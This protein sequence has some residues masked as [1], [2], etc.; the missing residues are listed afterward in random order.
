MSYNGEIVYWLWGHAGAVLCASCCVFRSGI[1][2][3]ALRACSLGSAGARAL[4]FLP[5]VSTPNYCFYNLTIYRLLN[6]VLLAFALVVLLYWGRRH[7]WPLPVAALILC[8]PRV[9][10]VYSYANSD[11]WGISM[12]L[13]LFTFAV[14]IRRPL[15]APGSTLLLRNT[16]GPGHPIEAA[17]LDIP[18]R[19]RIFWIAFS[20]WRRR[21]QRLGSAS[22]ARSLGLQFLLLVATILV[23]IGPLKIVYPLSIPDYQRQLALMQEARSWPRW[24]PSNITYPGF[25]LAARGFPFDTVWRNPEWYASSLASLYGKFGYMTVQLPAFHYRAMGL[26]FGVFVALTYGFGIKRRRTLSAAVKL[27]LWMAPVFVGANVLASLYNSWTYDFQ[28]QGRYLFPALM[29]L[30]LMLAGVFPYEP[31]W[32]RTLR[33]GSWVAACLLCLATLYYYVAADPS[34]ARDD[35]L[36]L[37][38]EVIEEVIKSPHRRL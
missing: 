21:R 10:Y 13:F 18:C 12:S 34:L 24:K 35:E 3:V 11:A 22:A 14:V 17:L 29:P 38:A 26:L 27:A 31:R 25:R 2:T 15:A 6:A 28:P 23:L 20:M 33:I 16:H 4:L 5:W 36:G 7:P 30:A 8:L 32:S 19:F 9:I 1:R 37:H